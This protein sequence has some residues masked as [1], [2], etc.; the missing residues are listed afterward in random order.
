M[1]RLLLPA[2]FVI[3]L[4]GSAFT[5]FS[6]AS[7]KFGTTMY[8]KTSFG[9]C[10]YTYII[11]ANCVATQLNYICEED[12]TG[13]GWQTML[14]QEVGSNCYQPFYSYYPNE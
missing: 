3:A 6:H 7:S 12:I 9:D 10:N 1:K 2:I 11:D 14:Q 5:Q 4:A 13:Y 8:Y